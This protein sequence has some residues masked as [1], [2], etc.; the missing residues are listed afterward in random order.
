M[1]MASKLTAK[2]RRTNLILFICGILV[3][4]VKLLL[5]LLTAGGGAVGGDSV[6]LSQEELERRSQEGVITMII[7]PEPVFETGDAAGNLLIENAE[8]N[9][10]PIV[11]EIARTDTGETIYRSGVIPVGTRVD[12]DS[13]AVAL[14]AGEYVCSA[15]FSYVDDVT[16]EVL[17]FSEI[18]LTVYVRS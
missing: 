16:E 7:N 18:G 13:L 12:E 3:I 2:Q 17:G 6:R 9:S 5:G 4:A 15:T 8:T 14:S 10:H 1:L 11:V